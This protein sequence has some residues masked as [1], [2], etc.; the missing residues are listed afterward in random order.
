[1]SLTLFYGFDNN[2]SSL[3]GVSTGNYTNDA[4]TPFGVGR[5][6]RSASQIGSGGSW[7]VVLTSTH[8]DGYVCFWWSCTDLS[9]GAVRFV[10]LGNSGQTHLE[11]LT[12]VGGDVVVRRGR[13]GTEIGRS[14]A[15]IISPNVWYWIEIRAV[16]ADSPSGL[17]EVRVNQSSINLNLTS[18]DTQNAG[19]AGFNWVLFQTTALTIR[20]DDLVVIKKDGSGLTDW[21]GYQRVSSLLPASNGTHYDWT[22]LTSTNASQVDDPLVPDGDS[23]YNHTDSVIGATDTFAMSDLPVGSAQ[24]VAVETL[25]T[26]RKMNVGSATITPIIR[27]GS[28]DYEGAATVTSPSYVSILDLWLTD[29]SGGSWDAA[30][31]NGMEVGYR[32]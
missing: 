12:G 7:Y 17:V 8:T 14:S 10:E 27:R 11:I 18:T 3:P 23:T 21:P 24:V 22:P 31:I 13:S 32:R 16:C 6:I 15:G 5:S 19:S 4:S 20:W 9:V 29:P 26:A 30:N 25:L 2:W 1:M 28:T